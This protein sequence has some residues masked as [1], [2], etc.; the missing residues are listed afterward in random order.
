[1]EQLR[2]V[3]AN[4]PVTAALMPTAT[5]P[6]AVALAAAPSAV[7]MATGALSSAIGPGSSAT[8]A[9]STAIGSGATTTRANEIAIG[10][11]SNIFTLAGINSAAS[12]IALGGGSLPAD[13]NFA[14]STN[15]G[16]FR[17]ENAMNFSSQYRVSNYIVLNGGFAA[18]LAG[19]IGS[20]A[21]ITFA[22]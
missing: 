15:W 3:A 12:A 17:D 7:A 13:K 19:G 6:F 8:F 10:T 2:Q 5:A 20:R 14:I 11:G 1:L 16:N 21:G 22:W 18:G 4:S 9:N